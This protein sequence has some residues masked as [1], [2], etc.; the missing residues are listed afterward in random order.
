MDSYAILTDKL[1]KL[2]IDYNVY[3]L[4]GDFPPKFANKFAN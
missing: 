4:K 3:T 1:K 2:A